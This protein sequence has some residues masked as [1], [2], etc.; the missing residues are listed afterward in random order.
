[1]DRTSELDPALRIGDRIFER[2]P[3]EANGAR[4]R[5]RARRLEPGHG[6]IEAAAPPTLSRRNQR[7]AVHDVCLGAVEVQLP[8]FPA[9]VPDLV[10]RLSVAPGRQRAPFLF[11]IERRDPAMTVSHIRYRLGARQD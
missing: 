6:A 11:E 2:T 3:R 1:A 9:V 10:D 4:R 8:R 5:M 7:P